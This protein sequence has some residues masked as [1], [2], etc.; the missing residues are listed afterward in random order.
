MKLKRL[1]IDRLPGIDQPFEIESPGA[2]V[3]VIFGPNAIGK[4]SICRAVEGLYWDDRGSTERTSITGQ[5][6]VDGEIWWAER[7]GARLRWRC[8][9][10]DRV[11]PGIPGSHHHR[12]FFLRLRDLIDPSL[13]GTQDI[14]SEIRRQMSGGFDLHRIVEVFFSGVTGRHGR[15]Q[16]DEFNAAAKEVQ[17]AEG[18]Q[19]AL[20]R[21]E[22]ALASLQ[23][24]LDAAAAGARRLP[25]VHRAVGLASRLEKYA[26]VKEEIAALPD[27]LASLTGQ[28]FEQIERHQLRTDELN[29][30]IRS[31][32]NQRDAA[33]DAVRES[34][35]SAEVN[36]PV[37][38][39][40]RQNAEE[41]GRIELELQN[42]RTHRAECH[43]EV[44]SA[45]S[46][47][48]G[49]DVDEPTLTVGEAGRLFEFLR[50]ASEHRTQKSAIAWRLR[51]LASIEQSEDGESRLVEL[52]AAVDLLRQWLRA[53][54]AETLQDRLRARR[55]W[56]LLAV[57]MAVLGAGMS[58]F[59]DPRFGLLLTVGAGV[60]VPVFLLY[61]TNPAS[62]TRAQAEVTFARLDVETP[63]KWDAGSVEARLRNLEAEV[64]SIES[65]SQRARDRD[66][67]R[68]SLSS[69]LAQLDEAE[70]SLDE[71]RKS[72]LKSLSL[73]SLRPDAELVDLARALDQLRATRIKY[74]GAA[75]RVNELEATHSRLLSDLADVLQQ[76]GEP[77]PKDAT[78]AKAYL[79]DLSDRN[80]RLVKALEDERQTNTQI[81]QNSNDREAALESVRQIYATASLADGDLP[82]LIALLNLL[83][84]YRELRESATRLQGQIGL[85]RE[86][87]A[88]AAEAELADLDR[89]SL[90]RLEHDLSSAVDSADDLRR[91]IA[92]INAQVNEAKRGNSLQDLIARRE[93]ARAELKNRRDEA[94]FSGAGRFLVDA[95]EREYEQTQM[96]RVFER[97]H[98]HF[99]AFTHHGYEL[100]LGRDAK[101]PRLF[102][103]DLR[104][105]ESRELNELS[106]GTRAQLL[107]AARM[108]FAEEV[109]Q[110]NTLPLFFDEALDQ[111]DPERF[112]AI[113]RSLGRIAN[114][115]GRQIFYLTSDPLDRD[116]IRQALDAESCVVAAEIDLGLL[117]GRAGSVTESS[118]LQVPT[119]PTVPSPDGTTAEEYGITLG[120]PQFAPALGYTRQHF[121]YVLPD[122][123]ELLYA[124]LT[125]GIEQAGQWK[126][127]SG[128]LLAERLGSRSRT[129]K[130]LDSRV[131]LLKVF[132]EVWNQGRGRAVD[133]DAL[134]QSRALSERYLDNV[135]AIAGELGGA[136]DQLLAVLLERKDSRLKGFRQSSADALEEYLRDN[137]HL[138]DR[139]VLEESD[140]SLRSLASPPASELPDGVAS[141]CLSRWWSWAARMSVSS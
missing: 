79:T 26:T 85:D 97:A 111:S 71:R 41:L 119:R 113:A 93:N 34:R 74:K 46:A 45:L 101:S 99:S 116:R 17:A 64:V 100:R 138:D 23:A 123:L 121:F 105:S 86:E 50:V 40:L 52:R 109:E 27:A 37:L 33:R 25:S 72:L 31:L 139:P 114:D 7:E 16:R 88:K 29:E 87:L 12:C 56:I 127:V 4:S 82:G 126:T 107:L 5:F 2:G 10:E 15:R 66:G 117:R 14:A 98:G 36:Q 59:V 22:D 75:G 131:N 103:I 81:D 9:D 89:A 92:G 42:A 58:V 125:N 18:I 69:Q 134:V 129:S 115:Q 20:Q 83:P 51:L 94:I 122:D 63:D 70:A 67:D 3:H 49:D 44:M 28:E 21:R 43:K 73:D 84:Q 95:V 35:L 136:S 140:L 38:A 137:G 91:E 55:V 130:E 30:R 120:V 132:C 141:A 78:T 124:L 8:V 118:A 68:Q 1:R 19:S 108:A 128:T 135:V 60:L 65:R 80:A 102:A 61:S 104:N 57:A 110:G 133:R 39:V 11:Q 106:D 77:L 76:H 32:E 62:T 96:P 54:A 24:Q 13:D 6:E 112:E 90:E 47:L 53:P 48:G